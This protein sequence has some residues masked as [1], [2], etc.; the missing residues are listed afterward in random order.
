MMN[1]TETVARLRIL[2]DEE[3]KRIKERNG[4]SARSE[5]ER[6]ELIDVYERLVT[7]VRRRIESCLDE[8][9]RYPPWHAR[10]AGKLKEFYGTSEV[11]KP[12]SVF[13]K[14]VFVM[15]KFP[16]IRSA[17]QSSE[18]AALRKVIESVESA[19]QT[20]GYTARIADEGDPQY[21]AQLWD[22]VELYL[23]GCEKGIVILEDKYL[24]ELNPNV[25]CEWGGCE[26][27]DVKF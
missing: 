25:A 14:S 21:H 22:N 5:A 1:T 13:G 10:H 12:A 6:D 18:D 17:H 19:V 8:L 24:P 2:F 26:R 7:E 20:F 16:Q 11:A 9:L 15:T 4:L 3:G 23:L 27:W